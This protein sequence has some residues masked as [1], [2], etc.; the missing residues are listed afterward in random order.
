MKY[1]K[2]VCIVEASSLMLLFCLVYQAAY[3]YFSASVGG[4]GNTTTNTSTATTYDLQDLVLTG[5]TNVANSTMIPGESVNYTFTINNPNNIKV[6]YGLQWDSV[7]NTFVNQADLV[8][9]IKDE[10]SNVIKASTQF[11]ATTTSASSIVTGLAIPASTT[12]TYTLTVTYTNTASLQNS[13][14]TKTF[15]GIISGSLTSCA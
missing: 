7:T 8:Y 6:C 2:Y 12:K 14:M 5:N 11:P 13:D 9:T 3:S 4:T 1:F 10:G 15:T